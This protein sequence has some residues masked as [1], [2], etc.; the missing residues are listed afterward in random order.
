MTVRAIFYKHL[1]AFKRHTPFG[2]LLKPDMVALLR[3]TT[4][5]TGLTVAQIGKVLRD[6]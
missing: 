5:D 3:A 4:R 2:V 1:A 6:G